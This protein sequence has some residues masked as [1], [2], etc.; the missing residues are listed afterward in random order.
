MPRAWCRSIITQITYA[1][2][3]K[4]YGWM[5]AHTFKSPF[6]SVINSDSDEL[7]FIP[8][9]RKPTLRV[10]RKAQ[11]DRERTENEIK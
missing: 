9:R 4:S 2:L 7:I 10:N 8:V 5:L 6:S 1:S 3:L 11:P